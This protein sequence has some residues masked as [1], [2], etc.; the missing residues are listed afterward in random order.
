MRR[1][2][3]DEAQEGERQHAKKVEVARQGVDLAKTKEDLA[4]RQYH[5]V[6][7]NIFSAYKA[8]KFDPAT[9]E[10]RLKDDSRAFEAQSA[11]NLA[12]GDWKLKK[13][14]L[15]VLEAADATLLVKQA[16]TAVKLAQAE[17]AG[18]SH[19]R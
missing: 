7:S 4:S 10:D 8:E 19:L 5:L 3:A 9:W 12:L 14:E 6:K 13:A 15:A 18:C 11:W 16:E 1:T 17:E 2:F